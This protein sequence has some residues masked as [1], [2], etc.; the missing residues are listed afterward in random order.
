MHAVVYENNV[1][2]SY[3]STGGKRTEV[4][5]TRR[6]SPCLRERPPNN[7]SN[8][9]VAATFEHPLGGECVLV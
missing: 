3:W 1:V 2:Y 6:D 4:G 8:A 9:A 5:S 7:L